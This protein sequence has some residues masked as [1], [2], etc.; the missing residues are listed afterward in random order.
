MLEE[1]YRAL[2]PSDGKNEWKR[3]NENKIIVDIVI[4]GMSKKQQERLE[5]MV[6][7]S[8][9]FALGK[10]T[11]KNDKTEESDLAKNSLM[12][13][14]RE[15]INKGKGQEQKQEQVDNQHRDNSLDIGVK[16]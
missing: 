8:K 7:D 14:M 9:H 1:L 16:R 12:N 4:S 2:S 15:T 3:N 11:H 13:N 6:R 5:D 10:V